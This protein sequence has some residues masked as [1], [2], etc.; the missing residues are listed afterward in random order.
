M[1]WVLK[2]E[3][4][5]QRGEPKRRLKD[6]ELFK[7]RELGVGVNRAWVGILIGKHGP[8]Y[9][10]YISVSRGEIGFFAGIISVLYPEVTNE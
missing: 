1:S 2:D 6:R 10:E 7:G 5:G 8:I 3:P 4:L 9:Y